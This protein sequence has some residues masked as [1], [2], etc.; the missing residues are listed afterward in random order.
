MHKT[1]HSTTTAINIDSNSNYPSSNSS[2]SSSRSSMSSLSSDA[3]NNK[4]SNEGYFNNSH[5]KLQA[6]T[7]VKCRTPKISNSQVIQSIKRKY[8]DEIT[9]SMLYALFTLT[10]K[11]FKETFTHCLSFFDSRLKLYSMREA[12]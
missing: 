8:S 10:M 9:E 3:V 5:F 2:M 12:C 7:N 4:S 11:L 1:V 6:N